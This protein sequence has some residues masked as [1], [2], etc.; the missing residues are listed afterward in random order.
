MKLLINIAMERIYLLHPV[1]SKLWK[2][3]GFPVC[4]KK[5]FVGLQAHRKRGRSARAS[6]TP[7]HTSLEGRSARFISQPLSAPVVFV[8]PA[9][10]MFNADLGQ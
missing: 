7:H 4:K 5:N 2:E 3:I 8:G 10:F 1:G 9:R 6:P